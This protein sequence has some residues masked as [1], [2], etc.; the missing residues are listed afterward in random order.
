MNIKNNVEQIIENIGGK[1]NIVSVSHC[2]TRIR[3]S[4]KNINLAAKDKIEKLEGIL[5][6]NIVGDEFQIIIGGDVVKYY[7]LLLTEIGN[8]MKNENSKKK[9]IKDY[10]Y[11]FLDF[12]SGTMTPLIPALIGASM[13]RGILIL[14]TQFNLMSASSSTY[15]ILFAASN[16][17]FYFLPILTAF[18]AA[19]KLDVNP[20][21]AA[22]IAGSLMEPN[23]TG[24]LTETGNIVDFLGIPVRMFNYSSSLIPA[25]LSTWLY[26]LAWKWLEKKIPTSIAGV[27]N[28][29]V[30]LAVFVPLTA[31]VFGPV[32][33]YFGQFIGDAFNTINN[34][35]PVIA[36]IFIGVSMNYLVI[37]GMHWVITAIC[38]NEF[39]NGYSILFG[40]WWCA[41]ISYIAIALGAIFVAKN[42]KERSLAI[43]CS[44]VAIFGGVS[45]PTLYSYLLRNKRYAIP[46]AISGALAGGLAGL[47]GCRA[48]AFS[49]ATIFTVPCVE[50]GGSF[51]TSAIVFLIAILA[52]II[53]TIIF[54]GKSETIDFSAPISGE[55][56][57]LSEV[58]DSIFSSKTLG[59]GFAIIPND[60]KIYAP[61]DAEIISLYPT[62]H[63][64]GLKDKNN[65][66]YLIHV[67]I[68]TVYLK[69]EGFKV[70]ASQG[71]KVKKGQLLL[72]FNDKLMKEKKIDM[73]TPIIFM[74]GTLSKEVKL[75]EIKA[76]TTLLTI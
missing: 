54:V 17:I 19:K 39:A 61:C 37:T 34:I 47:L 73:T 74:H 71:D 23:F 67:G 10:G 42:K 15:L 31:I 52:G 65:N 66:E 68:D 27:F 56:I 8:N 32:A 29:A 60:N 28:P 72:E 4:L 57:S 6:V 70:Y 11:A 33:Y 76:K 35:S 62:K 24:L 50:I 41:C 21:I 69:G 58:N 9:T 59:D 5:G 53:C 45:E 16:A 22:C 46:M 20:Y 25:L 64:L 38:L 51:V 14:L 36:G 2:A 18:S 55:V 43:S 3:L 1:E 75:G 7:P 63:A 13:I 12:I 44:I 40:Y 48:T 30:S 26:S 49:M